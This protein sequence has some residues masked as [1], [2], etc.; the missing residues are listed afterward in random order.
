[1]SL[2]TASIVDE[3]TND[4]T[5]KLGNDATFNEDV[6]T[7]IVKSVVREF[8]QRREYPED[9]PEEKILADLDNYYSTMLKVAEY[10][11]NQIGVEGQIGHSEN[12]VSRTY[13][14]RNSL[15]NDVYKFVK[16]L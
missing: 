1:M 3:I 7:V 10:D 8:V 16:F 11:F 12:G 6:L 2:N 5:T 14:D 15:F 9:Y 13:V 4:L